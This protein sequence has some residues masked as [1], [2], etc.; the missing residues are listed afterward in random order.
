MG[1]SRTRLTDLRSFRHDPTSATP[2]E[3]VSG[4]DLGGALRISPE[5]SRD[6]AIYTV[7]RED[8]AMPSRQSCR[9]N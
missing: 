7:H 5:A 2:P 3:G 6:G 9:W 1:G 8:S 4:S